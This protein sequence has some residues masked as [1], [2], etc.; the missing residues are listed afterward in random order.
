M[1][2]NGRPRSF[3]PARFSLTMT[4]KVGLNPLHRIFLNFA[5]SCI[6]WCL[7]QFDN[8]NGGYQARFL[9]YKSLKLKLRVFLGVHFVAINGNLLCHKIDSN[10]STNDWAVFYTMTL[11][12]TK[13]RM[14]IMTKQN[15]CLGKCWK[16]FRATLKPQN[17]LEAG[18]LKLF[19]PKS[20]KARNVIN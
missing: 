7:S 1:K 13:Y 11:A 4:L 15:L 8:K 2:V 6:L 14:V 9:S 10:M 18:R 20:G 5:K 19:C 3:G 12:S 16:L 17:N